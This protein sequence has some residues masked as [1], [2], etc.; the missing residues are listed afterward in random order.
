M[1]RT[2]LVDS[3]LGRTSGSGDQVDDIVGWAGV[4][5]LELAAETLFAESGFTPLGKLLLVICA[6]GNGT[7]WPALESLV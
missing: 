3:A 4:K 6:P 1:T 5:E 2:S 7:C